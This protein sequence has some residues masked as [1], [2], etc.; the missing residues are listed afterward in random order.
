MA[1]RPIKSTSNFAVKPTN[2]IGKMNQTDISD[3]MLIDSVDDTII[4]TDISIEN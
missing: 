4:K 1:P 2:R 3:K